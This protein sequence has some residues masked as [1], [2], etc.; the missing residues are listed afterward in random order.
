MVLYSFNYTHNTYARNFVIM[1][2]Y[3]IL[4][5]QQMLIKSTFPNNNNIKI[6]LFIDLPSGKNWEGKFFLYF[7]TFK[8]SCCLQI[9]ISDSKAFS[10]HCYF[11]SHCDLRKNLFF[12]VDALS[13]INTIYF[14][15]KFNFLSGSLSLKLKS[16]FLLPFV[17]HSNCVWQ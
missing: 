5:L 4:C 1:P 8:S 11:K 14:Q 15:K 13:K 16:L 12:T 10:F 2:A 9:L 6:T 3:L 7:P 17:S